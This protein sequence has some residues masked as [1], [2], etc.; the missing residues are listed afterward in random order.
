VK[1]VLP[2]TLLLCLT[3]AYSGMSQSTPKPVQGGRYDAQIEHELGS[4]L[5]NKPEYAQVRFAVED[6]VIT[7]QGTVKLAGE[8][9]A[10]EWK[11]THIDHVSSVQ[12]FVYLSPAPVSDETLRAAL[13]K[14]VEALHITTLRLTAHDGR[15]RVAGDMAN[16][17]EWS[18]AIQAI[19]ATPGVKEVED[20]TRILG[21]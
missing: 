17:R 20:A 21:E 13:Q 19:W 3:A 15:V 1:Y 9:N 8:K 7:L 11:A 2:L 12:N 10:L 5:K 18:R 4:F 16:R 6:G 14:T